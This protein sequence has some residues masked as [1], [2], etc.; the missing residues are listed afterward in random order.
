MV[1]RTTRRAR[2]IADAAPPDNLPA[3]GLPLEEALIDFRRHLRAGNK[4]PATMSVYTAGVEQLAAFLAEKGMPRTV[5]GVR[6]EHVE[7]FLVAL[8]ELGRRPST[9][10]TYYRAARQFFRWA[11][12]EDEIR[13]SPM[14]RMRPP[15]VPEEPPAVL[16]PEQVAAL[17][18]ATAGRDFESR[19]DRA[20]I[21]LFLHTGVRRAEL[22]GLRLDDLDRE[23]DEMLVMGKGRRPRTVHYGA[24]AG[25][26]LRRYLRVRREH[27]HAA[28]E[29]L[30]VGVKGRLGADGIRQ[31]IERRGTQAG[32]EGLHAHAFRH[33]FAHEWL[34]QGGSESDLMAEAGWRSPAMLR[35]YGASL[36]GERARA[37]HARLRLWK[38]A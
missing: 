25:E 38:D 17:M 26:A 36:A 37:A 24:E 20:V 21:T 33:A 18:K 12:D 27:P 14:A 28:S 3:L 19:R 29:W 7:A 34:S 8:A 10:E 4:S 1:T 2:S 11:V 23:R 13:E 31:L 6:R 35:R 16:R 32:I 22:A 9:V 30:W 5:D 15:I